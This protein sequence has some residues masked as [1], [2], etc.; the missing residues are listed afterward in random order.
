MKKSK[1]YHKQKEP[2][3]G[4]FIVG[5]ILAAVI[6]AGVSTYFLS[7]SPILIAIIVGG[8]GGLIGVVMF[9]NI[10]EAIIMSVIITFLIVMM[11]KFIPGLL[12]LKKFVVPALVGLCSG[13][14]VVGIW[15]ELALK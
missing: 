11:I 2:G 13:K 10:G 8:I 1:E 6:A 5:F 9:E 3:S 12:M 15:K 7:T 4:I 14:L